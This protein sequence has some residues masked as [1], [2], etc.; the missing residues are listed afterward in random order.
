M[1]SYSVSKPFGYRLRRPSDQSEKPKSRILSLSSSFK[2][3]KRTSGRKKRS[4][5]EEIP[6][7]RGSF[8]SHTN[9]NSE[10][11][12]KEVGDIVADILA[13][14]RIRQET[15]SRLERVSMGNDI[16][17]AEEAR[18]N[19]CAPPPVPDAEGSSSASNSSSSF[20]TAAASEGQ[21]S[22]S[23]VKR[24]E[25][26]TQPKVRSVSRLVARFE[27]YDVT[28]GRGSVIS[29]HSGSTDS[30]EQGENT[31]VRSS[32]ST[33]SVSTAGDAVGKAL[34][35]EKKTYMVAREIMSSEKVYVEV[36]K[37]I[38]ED[39]REYVANKSEEIGSDI[40]PPDV[41]T[42]IFS[43]I[44]QLMMFNSE[45]LK[46]FE[47]RIENWDSLKK[48][49]DVL[50]KKGPFLRLYATY[51]SDFEATTNLFEE[52]CSRYPCFGAAVRGFESM[53]KCG[54]LKLKM[55][56]LKPV[57]RLPQYKM[58]LE[59]Y[60]KHQGENSIDFDD[61]T[62]ALRIV[63]DAAAAANNNMKAGDQLQNMLKLQER[64]GDFEVIRPGRELLK[65]G[66][67]MKISRSEVVPRYFILLS[68]CLLYCHYQVNTNH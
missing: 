63:S 42:K 56:M 19:P 58:L 37:M 13:P 55:H 34:K 67:M 32:V 6:S 65:E 44:P 5:K 38:T 31:F 48:I 26:P 47:D 12:E 9:G 43:N 45:L 46:D 4:S 49:A 24:R 29:S 16:S 52:C 8:Q 50:V 57:Q 7:S 28:D 22:A 59:D 17:S 3:A 1:C 66:E 15:T 35:H 51:L 25:S 20:L 40:L 53:P 11:A 30:G 2:K 60:L 27:Q 33:S 64:V 14:M 23:P 36:L 10:G 61:T 62:E 18:P 54:N 41:L 21:S 68:D 39:F